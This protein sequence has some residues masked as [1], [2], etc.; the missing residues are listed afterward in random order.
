MNAVVG[1]LDQNVETLA[2]FRTQASSVGADLVMSPELSLTGYPPEDL[3]LKEG[4]IEATAAALADL[5]R[6]RH[7]PTILV[8]AVVG[9]GPGVALAPS[10]DGRDVASDFFEV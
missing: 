6:A 1:G 4:F 8:G 5:A 7:L 9:E 3:L 10:S 2:R